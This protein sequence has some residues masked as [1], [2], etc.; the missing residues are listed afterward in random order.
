MIKVCC[1]VYVCI[2]IYV[3]T[4]VL[5]LQG[6]VLSCVNKEL[7]NNDPP[8]SSPSL[9]YTLEVWTPTS[10]ISGLGFVHWDFVR[11]GFVLAPIGYLQ[12]KFK[13]LSW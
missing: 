1:I 10:K 12:K 13:Q 5:L 3:V 6:L 9:T 8:A 2:F 11:W 7:G 4:P